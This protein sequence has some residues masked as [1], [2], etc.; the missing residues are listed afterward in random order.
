MQGSRR[1]AFE[2]IAVYAEQEQ[3][4]NAAICRDSKGD[5]HPIVATKATDS[6]APTAH[7]GEAGTTVYI[8]RE[9]G[10][11]EVVDSVKRHDGNWREFGR[12]LLKRK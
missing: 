9:E 2:G 1:D 11:L 4:G 3:G 7:C 10:L 8:L 6:S 12:S 5:K